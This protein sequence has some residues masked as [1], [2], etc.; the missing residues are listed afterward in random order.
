MWTST[1]RGCEGCSEA[2]RPSRKWPSIGAVRSAGYR[3]S[4]AADDQGRLW[5]A[6]NRDRDEYSYLDVHV[7]REHA[8]TVRVQSRL[9]GFDVRDS[10][11][12]VL[13]EQAGDFP[14][15]VVDWY[16]LYRSND[17]S[18]TTRTVSMPN[19]SDST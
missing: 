6:T 4:A 10:T 3:Q 17:A 2:N 13:A 16:R 14:S 18:R 11:L 7:D 19:S 1:S 15:R 12:V 9:M 5:I 8:W